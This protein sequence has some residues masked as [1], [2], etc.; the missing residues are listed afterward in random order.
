MASGWLALPLRATRIASSH[1][2]RAHAQTTPSNASSTAVA[3]AI[4]PQRQ[5]GG[6]NPQPPRRVTAQ[7]TTTPTVTNATSCWLAPPWGFIHGGLTHLQLPQWWRGRRPPWPQHPAPALQR[8]RSHGPGGV[9]ALEGRPHWQQRQAGVAHY[10][11]AAPRPGLELLHHS[12][13]PRALCHERKS[14]R[15]GTSSPARC[16]QPTSP[17]FFFS[18]CFLPVT[19]FKHGFKPKL[20][21]EQQVTAGG[22]AGN[23]G[24]GHPHSKLTCITP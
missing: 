2:T 13:H 11:I 1:R 5:R 15:W 12:V 21:G 7:S 6:G 18:G 8:W 24:S 19:D 14:P 22:L 23:A 16:P 9:A 3:C 20:Q 4:R 17:F 10:C